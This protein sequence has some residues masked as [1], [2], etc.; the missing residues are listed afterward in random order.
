MTDLDS[1][2]QPDL[3]SGDDK[4]PIDAPA[5]N[6]QTTPTQASRLPKKPGHKSILIAVFL[7]VV[8]FAGVY[9]V[10]W[11]FP[12]VMRWYD[13]WQLWILPILP[14]LLYVAFCMVTISTRQLQPIPDRQYELLNSRMTANLQLVGF[15]FAIISFLIGFFKESLPIVHT[16]LLFFTVSLT[17]FLA[18][19][20]CL[21]IRVRKLFETISDGLV[22]NGLW[23][24]ILG[25]HSMFTA[26]DPL[27]SLAKIFWIPIVLVGL[28]AAVD[29]YYRARERPE[30]V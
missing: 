4:K 16:A 3:Q 6:K 2:L 21:F 19:Y 15:N 5:T 9:W 28:Y 10:S 23:A 12:S 24:I 13:E 14:L 17:C 18:S 27:Q 20:I 7:V 26:S 11:H 8:I 29:I 22:T 1:S 30:Q 25:L